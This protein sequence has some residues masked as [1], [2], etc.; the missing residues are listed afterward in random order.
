MKR[1]SKRSLPFTFVVLMA[2]LVPLLPAS[3]PE[4]ELSL[5][6]RY[7]WRGFDLNPQ[8]RRVLQPSLTIPIGGNGLA[9]NLWGSFSF[10]DRDLDEL[11]LTLS[12]RFQV[13][14]RY[15]VTVGAVQY[16]WYLSRDFSWRNHTSR[17]VFITLE[18]ESRGIRPVFS[19]YWDV[20]NG[21]GVYAQMGISH[22]HELCCGC[23][24]SLE[25]SATLGYNHRQWITASGFSDLDLGISAP[26]KFHSVTI[27]PTA[28][29]CVILLD[30]V[31]PGTNLEIWGGISITWDP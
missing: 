8:N 24:T 4:L 20:A 17:E 3:P 26:W 12:W 28:H 30:E 31:N 19:V 16:G 27:T 13:G 25:L 23:G 22:S 10:A 29:L 6:S 15:H 5:Y 11:D 18:K 21:S 7:I 1:E 14:N 2:L 9:V